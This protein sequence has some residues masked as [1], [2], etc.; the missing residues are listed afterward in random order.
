MSEPT[1]PEFLSSLEQSQ[2]L[3]DAQFQRLKK[4]LVGKPLTAEGLANV[5]VGQ[6]HLTQWQAKQ[7]LKGQSGL[8]LKH[9]RLLNPV[10][11]GGM[12]HVFRGRNT[13]TDDVIAVKVMAR[14]LTRN[15]TLVSRFRRE[16]RASSLLDSPHIV[17]TLDAGRVGKIDFMVMEY[18]NGDQVD[19][20]ATRLGRVP[21][22]MA[23]DIICQV[24]NGL[25]HAHE[26]KMVHRD[27]KPGNMM[28]HWED[29]GAGIVKLVD[30]GLVLLMSDDADEQTVTRA[31]Q[32]MGTPD[33]MSPEQGWDTSQVD[34]RSD[35]YSLGCTFFRLITG[36]IP[37]R[38]SNP[39]QVLS[40]RL[41]RDA[42]S[43]LTVCNDI[44][45]AVADVVSKMTA[46]N[47]DE[48][49]QTPA[50]VIAAIE[51]LCEPLNR[52]TLRA[53]AQVAN[54]DADVD[55]SEPAGDESEVDESDHTYKQFLQAV[56][57]GSAVDLMLATDIGDS[58]ETA[59]SPIPDIRFSTPPAP[60]HHGRPRRG[61]KA[62]YWVFGIGTVV[63]T[64]VVTLVL[65]QSAGDTDVPPEPASTDLKQTAP[66]IV[67]ASFLD[68]AVAPAKTGELWTYRP[69]TDVAGI[70]GE[71]RIAVG[72]SA[73]GGVTMNKDGSVLEWQVPAGQTVGPYT[74]RLTLVNAVDGQDTVIAETEINMTVGIGPAAI[75]LPKLKTVEFA[76]EQQ[77]RLSFAI[78]PEIASAFELQYRL[79]GTNPDGM[80][81]SQASG[82]FQWKPTLS[83]LGRHN[84]KIAV[85]EEGDSEPRDVTT[86]AVVVVPTDIR[87]VLP[88]IPR[89]TAT[90]GQ[91]FQLQLPGIT[92]LTGLGA[93]GLRVIETGP[94]TPAGFS[95]SR[96]DGMIRW[97][98][99]DDASGLVKVP[100]SAKLDT[101]PA[102]R[103]RNLT[104]IVL[105]EIDVTSPTPQPGNTLPAD[106]EV[107]AALAELRETYEKQLIHAR[108]TTTR[109]Q[110]ATH[111]LE[112]C[113]AAKAGATDVALMQLIDTDLAEKAR[114]TDIQLETARLRALRYETD[115][116]VAAETIFK[117]FRRTGLGSQQQDA[118]IEHGLRLGLAA[119]KAKH[120]ELADT[121]LE[122][123]KLLVRST[124]AQGA[125]VQLAQD[126]SDAAELAKELPHDSAEAT[127]SIKAGQLATLLGRWQFQDVFVQP[128][129]LTYV[130]A[131]AADAAPST[132]NGSGLWK[133]E[134]G[135]VQLTTTTQQGAIAF[136]DPSQQ[137]DRFVV[138]FD[139]LPTSNAAHFV[140]GAT[141]TGA[142]EFKAFSVV[143]NPSAM[144]QIQDFRS[145]TV[146]NQSI[147]AALSLSTSHANAVEVMVDGP[148]VVVRING[149]M[150][151]QGQ[152]PALTT[153]RIGLA[154]DLRRADPQLS[155]R[156]A[157]ILVLP[158]E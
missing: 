105:L 118:V 30:M 25:Q 23:C 58:E 72:G 65:T 132:D 18:V 134:N 99:P 61:Q 101:L 32:V 147:N 135:T 16:I 1:I 21:V 17:R 94:G 46:R 26:R 158:S 13:Q 140:F 67:K 137:L 37:F 139:L 153:G 110:L 138:R 36:Q 136:L 19:R 114:A 9:Y 150:V 116:F 44:P 39:L 3:T 69:K 103:S 91:V 98:V 76:P 12:G 74:I 88:E 127:I 4:Q 71:V 149:T 120:F 50:E 63:M 157:R 90:A 27:V 70:E 85:F 145:A 5:L 104:G 151:S 129:G 22:G 55:F 56:D 148:L 8:A 38:G 119:T 34:I 102:G 131:A 62:G 128:S 40:Q 73:P 6:E 15:K 146:Y 31:G 11:R 96:T 117:A 89:Q 112:Q 109:M 123:L 126:I 111:L 121:I 100:L 57:N 124:N 10:G 84:V 86:L 60:P 20:I 77:H 45:P 92:T 141:G 108:T 59:V 154:A 66:Q 80:K 130:Q 29:S 24:A 106:E 97:N 75:K 125:A 68:S 14:K 64:I 43:V 33:Y 7:L 133:I 52:Q 81:I 42:P 93:Q 143:L 49:Y 41:Q 47:P 48:R 82:E 35:I 51:P 107:S 122:S 79:E 155:V 115:E 83:D 142:A 87:H 53:A 144:G 95:I 78:A 54:N 113:Y 156:R 28:V 152:I 2:L